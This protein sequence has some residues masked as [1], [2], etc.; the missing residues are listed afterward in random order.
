MTT[1]KRWP[2][3]V[4][5]GDTASTRPSTTLPGRVPPGD[6][7]SLV[8]SHMAHHSGMSLLALGQALLGR[9][10]HRRFL[11]DPRIRAS[12]L[13]LQ[14]RVPLAEVRTRIDMTRVEPYLKHVAESVDTSL[15]SFTTAD[16]PVPEIHLLSNGRYHVMITA[17]GSGASRWTSPASQP[18]TWP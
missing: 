10:M 3:E 4:S 2:R 12:L 6:K 5:L 8:R 11:S 16:S 18:R 14:E 9:P 13:L 7:F 15:R 17:A 1:S